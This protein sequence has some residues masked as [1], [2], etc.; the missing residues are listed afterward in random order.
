MSSNKRIAR[1]WSEL[2]EEYSKLGESR[3]DLVFPVVRD[4]LQ[5]A[6]AET[7]LDF[8]CGDGRLLREALDSGA[9]RQAVNYDFAE[10]M[11]TLAKQAMK[12]RPRLRVV[13]SIEEVQPG[14]M[15][16]V[17]SV[18][19]WMCQP[20]EDA[21]DRMLKEIH[22]VLRPCG[23]LVAAVTHPCFRWETFTTFK[24][25]FDRQDYHRSGTSFRVTLRDKDAQLVVTDTHWNLED[26]TQQLHR[27]G[28]VVL[29]L[30]E[31]PDRP[32]EGPCPWLIVHAQKVSGEASH[33]AYGVARRR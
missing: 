4:I 7:V 25:D 13:R 5:S 8:G 19:V 28:F 1:R 15:Q 18:A 10:S 20:T 23:H 9:I 31:I 22:A 12:T 32:A 29:R 27:N 16:A 33:A 21:C 14:S 30:H 11:Y 3:Y 24:T 2:A 6:G 26:I 17:T